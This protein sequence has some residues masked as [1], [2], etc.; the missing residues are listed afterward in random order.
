MKPSSQIEEMVYLF[1][2]GYSLTTIASK[3]GV[4]RETVRRAMLALDID[5]SLHHRIS[6]E[7][8][9]Y[10]RMARELRDQGKPWSSISQ[11]LGFSERQLRR[12]FLEAA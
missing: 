10:G 8:R 12:Y 4:H 5:T 1:S 3:V 2:K 11:V 7:A 9:R 6:F